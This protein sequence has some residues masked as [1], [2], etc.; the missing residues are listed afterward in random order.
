MGMR[1]FTRLTNAFSKRLR[2][3]NTQRPTSCTTIPAH[4]AIDARHPRNGAGMTDKLWSMDDIVA[5]IE[6]SEPPRPETRP[7]K[8]RAT[9]MVNLN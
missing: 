8:K 6:A 4:S 1:R 9:R 2:T 3:T 5:L 7:Y